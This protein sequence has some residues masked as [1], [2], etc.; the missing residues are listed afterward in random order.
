MA[1][2]RLPMTEVENYTFQG[3]HGSVTFMDLKMRRHDEYDQKS[4][5]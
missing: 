3:E 4:G 2:W 5:E 1:V